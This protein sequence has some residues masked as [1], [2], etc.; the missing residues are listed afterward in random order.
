MESAAAVEGNGRQA[1][2]RPSAAVVVIEMEMGMLIESRR[3]KTVSLTAMATGKG[4]LVGRVGE[5]LPF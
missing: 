2:A 5:E 1:R 3:K 4:G